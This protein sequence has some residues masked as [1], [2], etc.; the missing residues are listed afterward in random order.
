MPRKLSRNEWERFLRGR[1][2]CVL[3]TIG[4]KGEPVLTPIWYLFQDGK[5]LVRTGKDSIKAHNVQR[6]PR[7]T[8]CVQDE[9]PPYKSV[10]VYGAAEILPEQPGLGSRIA[11]H[12]LGALGGAV[13]M[14]RARSSIEESAEITLVI[15]PDRVVT[16]D[17]S[18]ET[19]FIGWLWMIA[20]RIL[21]PWL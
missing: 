20:K 1:H 17:Y 13:Y 3:A 10:T 14:S 19:P 15:T 6:D 21:P 18:P 9:R 5:I 7:V 12:Y 8:V 11:R 16:Q 2:V 4:A